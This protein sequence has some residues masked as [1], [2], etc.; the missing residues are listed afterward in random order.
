MLA[1]GLVLV[2]CSRTY[3]RE[4]ANDQAYEVERVRQ[5]DARWEV[6]ARPVEAEPGSRM[7]DPSDPDGSPMPIDD[8]AARLFQVTRDRHF[9]MVGWRK[10]GTAPIEYQTWYLTLPRN[11][12]G[13]VRLDRQTVVEL[14]MRHSREYQ[15][16]VED[17]YL[18]AL[19]LT[20]QQFEFQLQP[21]FNQS[22]FYQNAGDGA[23]DS[24]QILPAT[25]AGVNKQFMTGA[26]LLVQYANN[27]LF[28][29]NGDGFTTTA[30]A[31]TV[32]F[33]QP[34]L[35]GAWARNV[36][37]PLSLAER[38]VLYR[39]RDFAHFRREF[40]V[41]LMSQSGYLGLLSQLQSIRNQEGL[42]A[43]LQRN[44]AEYDALVAGGFIALNE[45]D[46]LAQQLQQG[47]FQLASSVANLE[48][49]LDN[50][51]IGLGLPPELEVKLDDSELKLFELTDPRLDRLRG[52][53]NDLAVELAQTDGA[54]PVN[55]QL[56]VAEKLEAGFETLTEIRAEIL[57]EVRRWQ[58]K[59]GAFD[60]RGLPIP[61]P[62]LPESDPDDDER[63][64]AERIARIVEETGARLDEDR[65]DLRALR[66]RIGIDAEAETWRELTRTVSRR[67]RS[68]VADYYVAQSQARVYLIPLIEVNLTEAA[69]IALGFD[70]RLDLMN[71]KAQVTDAWRNE[72]V[73]A[74]LL[75]SGLTVQYQGSI[76][77]DPE[78]DEIFRFDASA[79]IHRFGVTFDAPI[80]RRAERNA[81]R[82]SQI[83]YQRARRAWMNTRDQVVFDVRL[84]LRNLNL[85][86]TQ[87]EIARESLTIAARQVEQ[88]EI[89]L[90][91]ATEA[92]NESQTL[93]LLNAL[94]SLLEAKNA[95]IGVWVAYETA[96]MSL[97]RD[98]D[99]MVLD[100]RGMWINERDNL[101]F[102]ERT[103]AAAR[104]PG[105]EDIGPDARPPT[106]PPPLRG[107]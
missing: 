74:N 68:L 35:R 31:I 78:F 87:F 73:A 64:L 4:F 105:A 15:F 45:R 106:P 43:N 53:A 1:L 59:L 67:F 57:A 3:Y 63:E 69:G 42:I 91:T 101:G 100:S 18:A 104:G 83:Q 23:T 28:E 90:R 30:T 49:A 102:P 107:P 72:E 47:E 2:G 97:F 93:Y 99:L 80:V 81:Y 85:L 66:A 6:P 54:A 77:N 51:K 60:E 76:A 13:A 55:A 61:L 20:L 10:R 16:Q 7:S 22:V 41:R 25:L 103:G 58:E 89:I 86:R 44:L 19:A 40:Y 39:V 12:D 34:L 88:T 46:T 82:A 27:L 94:Q 38:G 11:E 9:E 5:F 84:N 52:L 33:T 92:T 98:L 14:A 96:R 95:L 62:E 36:T 75:R 65:E 21:F 32:N 71:A 37:Q 70:N 24:N 29:F 56:R 8:P 79:G 26:Q 50:Y 17:L 48:T